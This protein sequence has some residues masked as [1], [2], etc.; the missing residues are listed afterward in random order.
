MEQVPPQRGRPGGSRTA[1]PADR[2]G[3]SRDGARR[4]MPC[5]GAH[6]LRSR[7]QPGKQQLHSGAGPLDAKES[8]WRAGN[9]MAICPRDHNTCECPEPSQRAPGHGVDTGWHSVT[10]PACAGAPLCSGVG[11]CISVRNR[12]PIR[13]EPPCVGCSCR[14]RHPPGLEQR[15]QTHLLPDTFASSA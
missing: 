9:R 14:R 5:P 10:L 8:P 6:L 15:K 4:R 12:K 11:D 2:R 3:P 13:G 7:A 1:A